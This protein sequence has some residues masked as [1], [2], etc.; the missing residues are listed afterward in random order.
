MLVHGQLH[1][2][3]FYYLED[4]YHVISILEVFYTLVWVKTVF[5]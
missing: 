2:Y 1:S 3:S 4:L 5:V